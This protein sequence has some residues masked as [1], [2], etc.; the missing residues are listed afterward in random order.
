M[1]LNT[2]ELSFVALTVSQ[3]RFFRPVTGFDAPVLS[4]D[5]VALLLQFGWERLG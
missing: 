1:A 5:V 4:N 3:E 2:V